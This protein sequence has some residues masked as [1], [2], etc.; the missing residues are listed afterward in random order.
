VWVGVTYGEEEY[1]ELWLVSDGS[2]AVW[3]ALPFSPAPSFLP[4][5]VI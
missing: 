2:Q 5:P 4:R 1:Y 3:L